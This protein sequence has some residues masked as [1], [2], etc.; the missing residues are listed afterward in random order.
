V[1]AARGRGALI[2]RGRSSFR[3]RD[4]ARSRLKC[5]LRLLELLLQ[6]RGLGERAVA[7]VER[8]P[9]L[10][11]RGRQQGALLLHV[12]LEVR[13]G[14]RVRLPRRVELVARSCGLSLGLARGRL[15]LVA[16]ELGRLDGFLGRVHGAHHLSRRRS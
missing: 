11:A 15:G 8:Q 9:G 10:L 12:R 13:D 1:G 3:A 14:D 5:M 4:L 6:P 16:R 7:L 2:G